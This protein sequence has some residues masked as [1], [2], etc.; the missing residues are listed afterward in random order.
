MLLINIV[1]NINVNT[2]FILSK[3]SC[4]TCINMNDKEIDIKNE[5]RILCNEVC[6]KNVK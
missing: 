2:S 4:N 3:L 1:S 6:H 5:R